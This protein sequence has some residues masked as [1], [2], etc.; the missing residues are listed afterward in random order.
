M[1]GLSANAAGSDVIE[2]SHV[3]RLLSAGGHREDGSL[4]SLGLKRVGRYTRYCGVLGNTWQ[5]RD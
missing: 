3:V 5:A 4:G 2:G 1:R